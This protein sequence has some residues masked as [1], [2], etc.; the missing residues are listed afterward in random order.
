ML[1]KGVFR[2][3]GKDKEEEVSENATIATNNSCNNTFYLLTGS[4]KEPN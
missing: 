1:L 3:H 4:W 2:V